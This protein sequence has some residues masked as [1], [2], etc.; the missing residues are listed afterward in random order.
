MDTAERMNAARAQLESALDAV[1]NATQELKTAQDFL[2]N[3]QGNLVVE[4]MR[5]LE[6]EEWLFQDGAKLKRAQRVH[7]GIAEANKPGAHAWLRA[8]G[9]SALLKTRCSIEFGKAEAHLADVLQRFVD[10]VIPQYEVEVSFGNTPEQLVLAVQT[11]VK[12]MFPAHTLEVETL[13]HPSTLKAFVTKQLRLGESLP[14]E[15]NVFA[16]QVAELELGAQHVDF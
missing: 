11:F 12:E 15:F 6:L 5:E 10:R 3:V 13:V 14:A 4:T 2:A 7:V 16:P 8:N 1:A 9:H